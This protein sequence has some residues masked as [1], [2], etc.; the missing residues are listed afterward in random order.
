MP[1]VRPIT[2]LN[3][4]LANVNSQIRNT[5]R[6]IERITAKIAEQT[7]KDDDWVSDLK[8]DMVVHEADLKKNKAVKEAK[9]AEINEQKKKEAVASKKRGIE[10]PE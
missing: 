3:F 4:E 7:G 5:E 8:Y 6:Q 9:E 2:R 10:L 1:A